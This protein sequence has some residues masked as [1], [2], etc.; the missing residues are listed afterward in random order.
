MIS[1]RSPVLK[2]NL[3][4]SDGPVFRGRGLE[5]VAQVRVGQHGSRVFGGCLAHRMT[6]RAESQ[7]DG[8]EHRVRDTVFAEQPGTARG[9]AAPAVLPDVF[10]TL[11]VGGAG[12][13]GWRVPSDGARVHR[14]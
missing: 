9:E 7:Y 1:C 3:G 11:D 2:T 4:I 10:D 13:V 14:P 12:G 5:P 8:R 6:V